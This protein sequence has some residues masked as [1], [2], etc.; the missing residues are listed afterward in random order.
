MTIELKRYAEYGVTL[1][2]FSGA[3]TA[4]QLIGRFCEL[5]GRDR[6]CWLSYFD[7]TVDLTGVDIA[8]LPPLKRMVAMKERELLGDARQRPRHAIVYGSAVTEPF[9]RFWRSYAAAGDAHSITPGVFS[10]FEAACDWLGLPEAVCSKL[11]AEARQAGQAGSDASIGGRPAI[12][13]DGDL[14]HRTRYG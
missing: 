6:G 14:E 10:N 2:V 9:F 7:P 3:L 13:R 8:H 4:E 1:M 11:G 12:R 5:D